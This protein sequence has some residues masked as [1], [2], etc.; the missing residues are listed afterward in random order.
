MI[1][2]FLYTYFFNEGQAIHLL[3][4]VT[5]YEISHVSFRERAVILE[6]RPQRPPPTPVLTQSPAP[7]NYD[8]YPFI[9]TPVVNGIAQGPRDPETGEL[10]RIE[11]FAPQSPTAYWS[12]FWTGDPNPD[13]DPNLTRELDQSEPSHKRSRPCDND[14]DDEPIERPSRRLRTRSSS[15]VTV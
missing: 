3:E 5:I 4:E 10:W 7:I 15:P 2:S 6:Q 14:N 8:D 1:G 13:Q 11:S 12:S 9:V